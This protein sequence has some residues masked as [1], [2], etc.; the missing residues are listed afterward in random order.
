VKDEALRE[1]VR[2]ELAL[3]RTET[4][5]LFQMLA[6]EAIYERPIS[7]RHRIIFYLGH[8]EAFDWNMI[9]IKSFGLPSFQP[10][11]DRL[12][13]F[14]IDPVDG[15]LPHDQPSDWPTV[16]EILTYRDRVRASVD[17]V[18][19]RST[20]TKSSQPFV[21]NAQIFDVAVEHRL[22]HAETLTY[23][24]HWLD[25]SLKRAPLEHTSRV[26]KE[27]SQSLRAGSS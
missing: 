26:V 16:P 14:G 2:H 15:A 1:R 8:L 27:I 18:L 23:M 4:D 9:C 20:F 7:E 3:A 24:F 25:Y 19:S 12:F 21:E 13:D 22:M 5:R 11:F 17:D 6:P 10:Q